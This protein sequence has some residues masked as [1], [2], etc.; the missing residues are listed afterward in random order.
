M[1]DWT[2]PAACSRGLA[3][4]VKTL[5]TTREALQRALQRYRDAS[6]AKRPRFSAVR[7]KAFSCA[8]GCN[9]KTISA[10]ANA[11]VGSCGSARLPDPERF[12][13]SFLNAL[14]T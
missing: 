7:G 13:A 4:P 9:S 2:P 6:E 8:A 10:E 12:C 1:S 5:G 14:G 11:A 3:P